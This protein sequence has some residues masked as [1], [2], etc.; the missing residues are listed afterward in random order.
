LKSTSA[1]IT[2]G[3]SNFRR[4]S[5]PVARF[6][7]TTV[8]A[9]AICL[10]VAACA[11]VDQFDDRVYSGNLESQNAL[12]NETLLNIVRASRYQSMN[13]IAITQVTGGLQ[14][15]VSTGLPTITIGPAQTAAQHQFQV[16][17]SVSNQATGGFQSNPLVST[18]FQSAML[19]P[20]SPRT[21]ALLSASHPREAV[22]YSLLDAIVL[23]D[24]N[25][26]VRYENN[27]TEGPLDTHCNRLSGDYTRADLPVFEKY[28]NYG[29][30]LELLHVLISAGLTSELLPL[31]NVAQKDQP[32]ASGHICFD[33][34]RAARGYLAN[35]VC[36]ATITP[37]ARPAAAKKT[38]DSHDNAKD[39]GAAAAAKA[40]AAASAGPSA[41]RLTIE[42]VGTFNVTLSFRSPASVYRFYGAMYGQHDGGRYRY[43][44]T[45]Y[46]SFTPEGV[47]FIT[48]TSDRIG[49]CY[50]SA[51]YEGQF[52]CAPRGAPNTALIF[53]MLQELR[54]LSIQSTDLNSAFTV[55]LSN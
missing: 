50:A 53:A 44:A 4:E 14:E 29:A 55:R 37:A 42:G 15:T 19:S 30:F 21:V 22:F 7:G 23:S 6:L 49:G 12:N 47:P 26:I 24:S 38:A 25:F 18:G 35:P 48:I 46:K 36:G 54:N 27:E 13:F 41:Q 34:S 8:I 45:A 43:R 33:R 2:L 3:I 10:V 28:C 11:V 5:F 17:N 9:V 32:Q 40:P 20:V 52:F 39:A 16:T 31:E 51:N 1:A